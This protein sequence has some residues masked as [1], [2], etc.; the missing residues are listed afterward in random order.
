MPKNV[1]S[2]KVIISKKYSK[3]QRIAIATEIIEYIRQRAEDANVPGKKKYS[4][5]YAK[6]LDFKIAG[7]DEGK[8]DMRLSGDMLTELDVLSEKAGEITV[9]YGFNSDQWGKAKGNILGSYGKAPNKK[10]A[11]PFLTL[12][13][14]DI[15]KILADY[16][17][18]DAETLNKTTKDRLTSKE[19]IQEYEFVS[20]YIED[21]E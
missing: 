20:D 13:S 2:E 17:L 18:D 19:V 9:G 11:R 5:G 10:N 21:D 1:A 7:K 14:N 4:P 3:E 8:V 16:P 12:S 15:K 6:S